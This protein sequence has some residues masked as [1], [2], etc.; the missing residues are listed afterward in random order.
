MPM[1][2]INGKHHTHLVAD[3]ACG[4]SCAQAREYLYYKLWGVQLTTPVAVMTSDAKGNHG[5]ITRL[6]QRAN[7]FGRGKE[8][9]K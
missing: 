4:M 3:L 9:F 2:S 8:S 7:W 6:M 1:T 5:H